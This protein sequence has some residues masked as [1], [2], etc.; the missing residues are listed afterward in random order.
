VGNDRDL[1][2][3]EDPEGIIQ[4]IRQGRHPTYKRVSST[5]HKGAESVNW[6]LQVLWS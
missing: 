1:E 4:G 6:E 2:E 3:M 5:E